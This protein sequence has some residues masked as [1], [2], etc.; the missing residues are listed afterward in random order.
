MHLGRS[1][2]PP[3]DHCLVGLGGRIH[4]IKVRLKLAPIIRYLHKGN[5]LLYLSLK[6]SDTLVIRQV[7][8]MLSRTVSALVDR[9][10]L[11]ETI[12]NSVRHRFIDVLVDELAGVLGVFMIPRLKFPTVKTVNFPEEYLRKLLHPWAEFFVNIESKE[13][14]QLIL[15]S[16]FLVSGSLIHQRGD[17]DARQ[18]SND[19]F[20]GLRRRALILEEYLVRSRRE[21]NIADQRQNLGVI[22]ALDAFAVTHSIVNPGEYFI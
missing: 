21:V 4:S 16:G 2:L 3:V 17:S 11:P 22:S 19:S 15:S 7:L 9:I 18:S 12:E 6:V 5:D 10:E 8:M 20:C 1:V 13:L 14:L